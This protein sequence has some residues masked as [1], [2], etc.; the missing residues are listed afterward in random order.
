MGQDFPQ[1]VPDVHSSTET[2][3]VARVFVPEAVQW[4]LDTC[5]LWLDIGG[6]RCYCTICVRKG[7]AG[8]KVRDPPPPS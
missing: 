1:C 5:R 6:S 3:S 2:T 7:L 8:R 4:K